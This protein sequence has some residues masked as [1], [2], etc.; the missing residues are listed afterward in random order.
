MIIGIDATNITQGGGIT[1]I[2]NILN[3]GKKVLQ[4][5][6]KIVIWGNKETL[7]HINKRKNLIK[8][9]VTQIRDKPIK[10]FI[11]QLYNFEK[12]LIS[13]KCDH[14]LILG[15][16]FF[17]NKTPA[18]IIMQNLLPF[19]NYNID[20]YRLI[21]KFKLFV[22]K[23]L[24]LK[25][26]LNAKNIIFLSK[27]SKNI[28]FKS[29][30]LK[31]RNYKIIPHGIEK[32]LIT[33]K[34]NKKKFFLKKKS[35]KILYVSKI[36]F[37]K[38][39]IDLIKAG[40]KLKKKNYDIFITFVGPAYEP[41]LKNFLN[42]Q[43]IYDPKKKYTKYLG[44]QS[45]KKTL[46]IYKKHDLHVTPSSCETF[47]QI[48]LEAMAGGVPNVCSN[49]EVF[50]EITNYNAEFFK[51]GDVDNMVKVIEKMIKSNNLRYKLSVNSINYLR[52]N[53]SWEKTSQNT[54]KLISK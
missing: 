11:W 32:S 40:Y 46:K 54:F 18:T 7:K 13:Y 38:N 42:F 1:H 10:R 2:K 4:N 45:F 37:Y 51:T 43:K 52:K 29:L 14:A 41:A 30:N 19:D 9:E 49:L 50:K 3:N 23:K 24:L 47:G 25:S 53:F 8:I 22:Q 44:N 17:L 16:I 28:I 27:S 31:L 21:K 15:G 26:I 12:E 20:K 6:K 34:I 35:F 5:Y 36:E 39:Q 33:K 48:V